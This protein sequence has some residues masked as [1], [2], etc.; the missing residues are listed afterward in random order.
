MQSGKYKGL[1]PNVSRAHNQEQLFMEEIFR[2]SRDIKIEGSPLKANK[3]I[4]SVISIT[5]ALFIFSMIAYASYRYTAKPLNFNDI[6]LARKD[7][8]PIKTLPTEPGGEK[9]SNQD[10]MIYEAIEKHSTSTQHANK[11]EELKKIE[12]ATAPTNKAPAPTPAKTAEVKTAKISPTPETTK[13]NVETAASKQLTEPK[14][15]KTELAKSN[16]PKSVK[17]ETKVASSNNK[18]KTND[19]KIASKSSKNSKE[20]KKIIAKQGG[21]VFDLVQ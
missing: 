17:S 10:K 12:Q 8:G 18:A 16:S 2:P 20:A 6:K 1:I 19:K 11:A 15:K 21:S 9:F 7:L 3:R 13:A 5:F 4:V 14:A